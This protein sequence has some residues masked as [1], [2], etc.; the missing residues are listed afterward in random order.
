MLVYRRVRRLKRDNIDMA[1]FATIVLAYLRGDPNV[2][3]VV[4]VPGVE[5][6]RERDR[7][8]SE[9]VQRVNRIEGL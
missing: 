8:I 3:S 2:W 6:H 5:L 7:L 9:R 4:R 1:Q